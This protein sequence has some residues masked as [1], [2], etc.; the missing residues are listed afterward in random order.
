MRI[1]EVPH[2]AEKAQEGQMQVFDAKIEPSDILQGALGDCYFLSTLSVLAEWP[3]RIRRLFVNDAVNDVGIYGAWVTKNG[4][5]FAVVVDDFI[6]VDGDR[7]AFSQAHGAE[8]WVIILE[9]VW[10][11]IHGSYERIEAGQAHLTMRDLTGAPSYEYIIEETPGV[12]DLILDADQRQYAITGGCDP[13]SEEERESLEKMG[14]VP[15]HCYGIIRAARVK[16][17]KKKLVELVQ[18]RNP[19]GNFEWTGRWGDKSDC[20]TKKLKKE[21]NY[22]FKDDGLF[23]MEFQDMKKFFP[24]VQISKIDDNHKYSFEKLKGSYGLVAF[25]VDEAGQHTFT[26]A[27]LGERMVPR[28][29]EYQYS[30]GRLFLVRLE[31]GQDPTNDQAIQYIAGTKGFYRRDIHLECTL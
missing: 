19:W 16:D 27:Q 13:K 6:P 30:D 5:R 15:E 28:D 1:P 22:E 11:K 18:L 2:I 31:D 12:F 23:W 26:L 21:L 7:P 10:A 14:L 8:L 3:D 20:W 24:R 29:I 17:K 9:K 4:E 25:K